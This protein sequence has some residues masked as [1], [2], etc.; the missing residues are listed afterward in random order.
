MNILMEFELMFYEHYL[1]V[2]GLDILTAF[3]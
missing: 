2:G 3:A 1:T